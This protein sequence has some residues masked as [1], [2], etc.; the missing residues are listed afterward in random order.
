MNNP[1]NAKTVKILTGTSL[2]LVVIFAIGCIKH[3]IPI[4]PPPGPSTTL[5]NG[6]LLYLPFDGNVADSSGNHNASTTIGLTTDSAG[7]LTTDEHGNANSAWGSNGIGAYVRVTNNGSIKY[8]SA[9]SVSFNVVVNNN[10]TYGARQSFLSFVNTANAYGPGIAT[11]LDIPNHTNYFFGVQDSSAGCDNIGSYVT[12]IGDTSAFVPQPGVWYN[13]INVY[14]Q[15]TEY[16]YVNGRLMDA[17]TNLLNHGALI[18]P[19]ATI[20]IGYW[21]DSDQES[22]NGKIDEIRLYNRVLTIDEI[23]YLAN[24]L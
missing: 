16:V 9:F 23:S 2:L 11:G 8:D 18:C 21:W 3:V 12:K 17:K 19:E 4:P 20:N 1:M 7:G 24:K 14:K 5:K 15:G 6:L 22:L 13:I 10:F